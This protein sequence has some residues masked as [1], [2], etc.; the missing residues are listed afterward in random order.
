MNHFGKTVD[1]GPDHDIAPVA[2]PAAC[3]LAA[4]GIVTAAEQPGTSA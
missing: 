2:V 1:A 4:C 3:D